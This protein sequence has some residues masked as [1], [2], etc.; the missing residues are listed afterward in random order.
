[1]PIFSDFPEI[2]LEIINI[3]IQKEREE[4]NN[5]QKQPFL[6]LPLLDPPSNYEKEPKKENNDGIIIIE[7]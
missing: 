7:L 1:M 5:A 3:L 6:Q 2:N 4:Q